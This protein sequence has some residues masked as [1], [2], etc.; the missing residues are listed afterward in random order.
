M[1]NAGNNPLPRFNLRSQVGVTPPSPN[2]APAPTRALPRSPFTDLLPSARMVLAFFQTIGVTL[3]AAP[4]SDVAAWYGLRRLNVVEDT[5]QEITVFGARFELLPCN[6]GATAIDGAANGIAWGDAR[7]VTAAIVIGRRLPI[8]VGQ[9]KYAPCFLPAIGLAAESG[10]ADDT[11]VRN[12]GQADYLHVETFPTGAFGDATPNKLA[13][14]R[15]IS[16]YNNRV[17]DGDTLD[18]ALVMRKS[19]VGGQTNKVIQGYARVELYIGQT[20]IEA[21]FTA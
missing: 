14:Y 17:R 9:W 11:G 3:P 19:Y 2:D 12:A 15:N 8:Q 18:V 10:T 21:P 7:G 16:P 20:D 1:K 5:G 4:T 13:E 6:T